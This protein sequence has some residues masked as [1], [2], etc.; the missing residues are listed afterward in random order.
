[1]GY[2]RRNDGDRERSSPLNVGLH[3]LSSPGEEEVVQ[4][5]NRKGLPPSV[6]I[7][8]RG[9]RDGMGCIGIV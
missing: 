2:S 3:R 9:Q 4:S 8:P 1:M 6:P 7:R 5:P